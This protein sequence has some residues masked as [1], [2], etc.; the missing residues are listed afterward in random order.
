MPTALHS[1]GTRNSV[2]DPAEWAMAG[3]NAILFIPT[4]LRIHHGGWPHRWHAHTTPRLTRPQNTS[5]NTS[6]SSQC[7]V[8][9]GDWDVDKAE[10]WLLFKS[11]SDTE[12]SR[13]LDWNG[14][15]YHV[16]CG[17]LRLDISNSNAVALRCGE[18]GVGDDNV[19]VRGHQSFWNFTIL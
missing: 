5:Q 19:K 11:H 8:V 15:T 7:H 4:N 17:S 10:R 1:T 3:E 6:Q 16:A 2:S 18:Q 13:L 12:Q 9:S 14:S